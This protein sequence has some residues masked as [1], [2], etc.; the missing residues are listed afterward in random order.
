MRSTGGTTRPAGTA[1][2]VVTSDLGLAARYYQQDNY[3]QAELTYRRVQ[4]R[5]EK[6]PGPDD[7]GLAGVL[8]L[9]AGVNVDLGNYIQAEQI[10]NRALSILEES[11]GP[12]HPEIAVVLSDLG[13]ICFYQGR[14]AEAES[15]YRRALTIAEKAALYAGQSR[16][17]RAEPLYRRSLASNEKFWGPEHPKVVPNLC[18]LA[19]LYRD[20]TRYAFLLRKL[21]RKTE[22][23]EVSARART[24]SSAMS[25]GLPPVEPDHSVL[26]AHRLSFGDWR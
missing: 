10:E 25:A 21:K 22:A 16:F 12:E 20:L 17:L 1:A 14:N 6:K 4:A 9:L 18:N 5:M 2:G 11:L 8:H 15:L 3:V 24:A 7:P 19:R 26:A 23:A 13:R